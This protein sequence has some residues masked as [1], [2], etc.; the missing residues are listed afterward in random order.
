MSVKERIEL[1]YLKFSQ[2]VDINIM[3]SFLLSDLVVRSSAN[4]WLC[5]SVCC[6]CCVVFL[7]K[8]KTRTALHV[9][10]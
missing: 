4:R 9:V 10:V 7:S 8:K 1:G 6:E 3:S 5:A 2:V